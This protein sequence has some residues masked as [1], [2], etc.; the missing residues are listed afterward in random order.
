MPCPT[1]DNY[2]TEAL[3]VDGL[4]VR[5]LIN[6]RAARSRFYDALCVA[7]LSKL[8]TT[9][10]GDE[11]CAWSVTLTASTRAAPTARWARSGGREC[12]RRTPTSGCRCSRASTPS[13]RA[14]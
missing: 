6:H 5:S 4:N 3:G 10:V 13:A 9:L 12:S 8:R 11:G 7:A 2:T 1:D 14:T